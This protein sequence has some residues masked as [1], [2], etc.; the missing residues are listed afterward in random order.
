ML[1]NF[2]G[3][4]DFIIMLPICM[5]Q[6]WSSVITILFRYFWL[7]VFCYIKRKLEV[8][9]RGDLL[10]KP[11]IFSFSHFKPWAETLWKHLDGLLWP[12]WASDSVAMSLKWIFGASSACFQLY[13]HGLI[14]IDW[15]SFPGSII[16]KRRKQCPKVVHVLRLSFSV[17]LYHGVLID[18]KSI[19]DVPT[20]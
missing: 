12:H 9:F 18:C 19:K 10:L 3:C 16:K 7:I 1:R 6:F 15:S 14:R 8:A 17:F 20:W 11:G 5:I 13:R 4:W 2:C